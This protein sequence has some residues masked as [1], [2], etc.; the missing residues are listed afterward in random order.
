[1][2][3]RAVRLIIADPPPALVTACRARK[4]APLNIRRQSLSAQQPQ[5]IR[6]MTLA[7]K[8]PTQPV[9]FGSAKFQMLPPT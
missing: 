6:N 8:P 7:L 4:L 2:L 1:M 5:R 3:A 9:A